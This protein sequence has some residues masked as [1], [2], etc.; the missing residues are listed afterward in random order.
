MILVTVGHFVLFR[1]L[2]EK[3]DAY[4][5]MHAE[6]VLIQVPPLVDWRPRHAEAI[7]HIDD[8][9]RW[10]KANARVVITHGAMTLV[11]MLE[12][13]V[14]VIC[15]PRRGHLK[16]HI[17]DHQYTFAKRLQ[18]KYAFPLVEDVEELDAL[19]ATTPPTFE[20]D[21]TERR[22]LAGFMRDQLHKW[23]KKKNR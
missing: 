20:F 13:E 5:A 4:A 9:P 1:R 16:E 19:L 7:A 6:R 3:M 23:E 2:L 22:Q 17:N 15:V 14:P 21:H 10:A 8:L 12:A 11:E 18:E